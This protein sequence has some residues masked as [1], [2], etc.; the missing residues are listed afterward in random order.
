MPSLWLVHVPLKICCALVSCPISPM[1]QENKLQN[2]AMENE[3]LLGLL[4]I[5]VP[6]DPPQLL[7]T[8]GLCQK[9]TH[10]WKYP[11]TCLSSKTAH[12][13]YWL[14]STCVGN[15]E[16]LWKLCCQTRQ[17]FVKKKKKFLILFFVGA[18]FRH[19]H[20]NLRI[21][22]LMHTTSEGWVLTSW[23]IVEPHRTTQDFNLFLAFLHVYYCF[24]QLQSTFS[25]Q[26]TN[27]WV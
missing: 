13:F 22:S 27:M 18:V 25:L 23:V 11:L 16:V 24:F 10:T 17:N 15:I 21:K 2:W 1:L 6:Q 26:E 19:T 12:T 20:L 8:P 3:Q 5:C 7:E 4:E 9:R 14:V